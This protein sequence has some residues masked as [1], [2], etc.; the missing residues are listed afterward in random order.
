MKVAQP[1]LVRSVGRPRKNGLR[2]TAIFN[3]AYKASAKIETYSVWKEEKAV[4]IGITKIAKKKLALGK[5]IDRNDEFI[6]PNLLIK[7]TRCTKGNSYV[8]I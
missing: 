5:F 6:D 2:L 4:Q 8:Q 1:W 7:M 3:M